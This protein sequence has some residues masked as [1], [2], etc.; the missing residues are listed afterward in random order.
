MEKLS[1]IDKLRS[2]VSC[3]SLSYRLEDLAYTR[4]G[5]KADSCNVGVI[6]R[7]S[8]LYPYLKKALTSQSLAEYFSHVFPADVNPVACVKR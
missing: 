1:I 7:H 5:D 3:F 2:D 8:A 6:A 4:S